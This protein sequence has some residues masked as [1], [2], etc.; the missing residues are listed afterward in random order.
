M[1]I[2]FVSLVGLVDLILSNFDL[3]LAKIFG[4]LFS[5]LSRVLGVP[6]KEA[7]LVGSLIMNKILIPIPKYLLKF[8]LCKNN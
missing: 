3:T 8:I 5:P 7:N 2:A 6:A 4:F 1:V